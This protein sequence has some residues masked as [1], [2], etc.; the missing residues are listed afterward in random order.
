M[1]ELYATW[2]ALPTLM[3]RIGRRHTYLPVARWLVVLLVA[4]VCVMQDSST[5]KD[6]AVYAFL[7]DAIQDDD[8]FSMEPGFYLTVRLLGLALA[9]SNLQAVFFFCVAAA[10]MALKLRLFRLYGKRK[11]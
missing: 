3:A 9:G 10:S 11:P 4:T 1:F 6:R 5:N 7:I 8:T 2:V